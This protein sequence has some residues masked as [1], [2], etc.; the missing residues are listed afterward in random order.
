MSVAIVETDA[1]RA[2]MD[3][4]AAIEGRRSIAKV[5][6][7]M[8]PRDAIERILEAATWAPNHHV[9]EPWRFVVIAGHARESLGHV[10][11]QAKIERMIRQGKET[12]GEYERAKAKAMRAPVII[13]VA[14]E[15]VD[16]PKSVAIEEIEAGGAAVQNMLL[17]AHALGLATIWRTGDPA[18]D[19]AVKAH[20]GFSPEATIVGFVYVGYPATTTKRVR[21]TPAAMLTTWRG[22]ETEDSGDGSGLGVEG[23][24]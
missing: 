10:M 11:A 24:R 13:A 8:P 1:A 18:Y 14:S 9:T 23:V 19:P 20:L 22:F 4:F 16:H 3:V 5:L 17:A 2:A 21:R 12:E 7:E 15:P 6:P